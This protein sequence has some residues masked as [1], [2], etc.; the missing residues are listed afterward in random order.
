M[1]MQTSSDPLAQLQDI[2][3]PESVSAWPLAWG[4]WVLILLAL[5]GMAV[6]IY[7]LYKRHQFFQAK[8]QAIREIQALQANQPDWAQ[9][10]NAIL[11]RTASYYYDTQNVA[12]L[13][14]Q[15]WQQFLL[16]CLAQNAK[17]S[18]TVSGLNQLQQALYQPQPLNADHFESCQRACLT[19]LKR[20]RFSKPAPDIKTEVP[21]A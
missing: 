7:W 3:V 8:R 14:G 21:Y 1:Q 10:Q 5:V 9:Q 17:K 12:A 16:E 20:A 4:W 11:K 19:W 13:Y 18:K 15:R 6:T 2:H